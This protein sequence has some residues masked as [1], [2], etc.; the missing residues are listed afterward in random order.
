MSRGSWAV[1]ELDGK[2]DAYMAD[3]DGGVSTET[4]HKFFYTKPMAP[5]L[6]FLTQYGAILG[7]STYNLRREIER[8]IIAMSVDEAGIKAG[9]VITDCYLQGKTYNKVVTD[10]NVVNGEVTVTASRRGARKVQFKFGAEAIFRTFGDH[11][12]V[13][14]PDKYLTG[15]LLE[16]FAALPPSQDRYL[17]D[18]IPGRFMEFA[19]THLEPAMVERWN[20]EHG[21]VTPQPSVADMSDGVTQIVIKLGGKHDQDPVPTP[22]QM[23]ASEM[24]IITR[25]IVSQQLQLMPTNPSYFPADPVIQKV[26]AEFRRIPA[27]QDEVVM[28]AA[29]MLKS[30]YM[31]MQRSGSPLKPVEGLQMAAPE[32]DLPSHG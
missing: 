7:W 32:E 21:I 11:I 4:G 13:V 6:N 3:G 18:I 8:D 14:I 23:S 9:T 24:E 15:A 17:A 5:N 27:Y 16:R 2:Y 29:A 10:A 30:V 25:E 12:K 28:R 20:A 31:I 19:T 22:N 26:L 1:F